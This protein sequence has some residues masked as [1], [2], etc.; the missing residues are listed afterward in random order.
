MSSNLC[1][2]SLSH[3]TSSFVGSAFINMWWRGRIHSLHSVL[4]GRIFMYHI[5]T[6]LSTPLDGASF[7]G[8]MLVKASSLTAAEITSFSQLLPSI[9]I[10][11]SFDRSIS[12]SVLPRMVFEIAAVVPNFFIIF[13][14][15]FCRSPL[16]EFVDTFATAGTLDVSRRIGRVCNSL[17]AIPRLEL[18]SDTRIPNIHWKIPLSSTL[19]TMQTSPVSGCKYVKKSTFH[20]TK[21]LHKVLLYLI[22]SFHPFVAL[23]RI[24]NLFLPH[25]FFSESCR[26]SFQSV[27]WWHPGMSYLL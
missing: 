14:I 6:F 18:R 3:R 8:S 7:S 20:I 21:H 24:A 1:S 5:Q 16:P 25:L 15:R 19:D 27:L 23:H 11:F 9:S 26:L 10:I 22:C 2:V 4:T 17:G 13:M 12:P